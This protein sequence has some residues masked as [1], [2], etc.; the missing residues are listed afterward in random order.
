MP[1]QFESPA[2]K[3]YY[4][5][6]QKRR[7]QKPIDNPLELAVTPK[8]NEYVINKSTANIFIGTLFELILKNLKRETVIFTGIATE[9]GIE[10]SA[11][12]AFAHG[13]FAVVVR[14]AV[15]SFDKDA[16]FHS[17]ENMKKQMI[18]VSTEEV[19]TMY[20]GIPI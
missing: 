7:S 15:S 20:S 4:A 19:N 8:N 2:R 9:Y 16:H 18:L 13:Y 14:D 5:M 11:R 17:L 1:E 10:T 3:Y 12:D 6:L